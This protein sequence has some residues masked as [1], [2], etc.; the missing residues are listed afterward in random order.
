MFPYKNACFVSLE[1]ETA[2]V[3]SV[4]E[5]LV[6]GFISSSCQMGLCDGA[7]QLSPFQDLWPLWPDL[8]SDGPLQAL[9]GMCHFSHRVKPEL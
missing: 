5:K 1:S 3:D 9:L 2:G 8:H 7:A 4:R 6:L